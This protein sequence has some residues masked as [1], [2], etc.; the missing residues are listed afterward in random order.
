MSLWNATALPPVGADGE[1][2][3]VVDGRWTAA[4]STGAGFWGAIGG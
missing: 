1:V 2:L 4:P 3:T